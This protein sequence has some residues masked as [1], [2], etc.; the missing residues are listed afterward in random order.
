MTNAIRAYDHNYNNDHKKIS[1]FIRNE[2][3]AYS[4]NALEPALLDNLFKHALQMTAYEHS[5]AIYNTDLY[6]YLATECEPV[7]VEQ[8]NA[9]NEL[10]NDYDSWIYSMDELE[11]VLHDES[12]ITIA[13]MVQYGDFNIND[14]YFSF[15]G[16]GNLVS[17]NHYT[18]M[19]ETENGND[20]KA[21]LI[22]NNRLEYFTDTDQETIETALEY[23]DLIID[24]ALYMVSLGY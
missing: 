9:Y 12:P 2:Y 3:K 4:A 21:A 8:M 19:S 1:D 18:F 11:E 13:K 16:Y 20:I 22:E 24:T 5:G 10:N 17:F 6:Q 14:D 23:K 7:T 15:N